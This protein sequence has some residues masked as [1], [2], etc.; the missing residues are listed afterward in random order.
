M[1]GEYQSAFMKGRQIVDNV[2]LMHD[3]VRVYNRKGDQPR[4]VLKIIIMKAYDTLQWDFLSFFMQKLGF[5]EK[6]I[7]RVRNCV[8]T[9]HFSVSLNG[10]LVGYFHSERGLRKSF[11]FYPKCKL[12]GLSHLALADD[13]FIL[14]AGTIKSFQV[15]YASLENSTQDI[16]S[17]LMQMNAGALQ[18]KHMGLPLISTR[19]SYKD[20]L[21]VLISCN[22]KFMAGQIKNSAMVEDFNILKLYQM[23]VNFNG[24]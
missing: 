17:D 11:N 1:I 21:L 8:S 3:L 10:S 7:S 6:F 15:F 19:L 12:L 5:P 2:L 13:L 16:L 24:L 22:R 18:V 20:C 14:S 4:A 23:V 9:A